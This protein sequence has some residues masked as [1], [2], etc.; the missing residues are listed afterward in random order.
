MTCILCCNLAARRVAKG[1]RPLGVLVGVEPDV[2]GCGRQ[3]RRQGDVVNLTDVHVVDM[4]QAAPQAGY[5]SD[6][7]VGPWPPC[8]KQVTPQAGRSLGSLT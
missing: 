4:L 2:V 1:V 5:Q 6:T 7:P 8:T 3:A